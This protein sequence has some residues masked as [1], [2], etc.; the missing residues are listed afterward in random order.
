M[1]LTFGCPFVFAALEK[2]LQMSM[3]LV[4]FTMSSHGECCATHTEWWPAQCWEKHQLQ[5]QRGWVIFQDLS[6]RN[7]RMRVVVHLLNRNLLDFQSK[8]LKCLIKLWAEI[9][10]FFFFP[11]RKGKPTVSWCSILGQYFWPYLLAK[12][13]QSVLCMLLK[14]GELLFY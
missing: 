6:S 4:A 3:W 9:L 1:S 10:L 12:A 2:K 11:N 8:V 13:L 7:R 14:N 5:G